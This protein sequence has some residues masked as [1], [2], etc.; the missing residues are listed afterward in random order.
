M[1]FFLRV[2]ALV[3]LEG[4]LESVTSRLS[5]GRVGIGVGLFLLTFTAS[6]AV[7]AWLL[8]KVPANYFSEAHKFDFFAAARPRCASPG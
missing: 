6:L 4:W 2:C 3:L 8:V 7:T 5:W 1:N